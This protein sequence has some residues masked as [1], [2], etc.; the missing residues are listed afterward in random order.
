M[1]SKQS[2]N[3]TA[4][5]VT[6]V[7]GTLV[8][9]GGATALIVNSRNH[10]KAAKAVELPHDLTV[11]G[12]TQNVVNGGGGMRSFREAVDS[13]SLTDAQRQ[14]AYRNMRDVWRQQMDAHVKEF[15]NAKTPDEKYAVLDKH[16]DEM[17]ARMKQWEQDRKEREKEQKADGA[18]GANGGGPNGGR[19]GFAGM[20]EQERKERSES[21]NPDQRAEHMAYFS[22]VQARATERGIPMPGPGGG[23]GPGGGFGRGRR[24]P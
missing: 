12:I 14:Q 4:F 11:E 10:A 8:L 21:A 16:L 18:G 15:M 19:G 20:S 3:S 22:A 5:W 13:E 7:T 24:G 2:H 9:G 23:G 17:Q 6:I 1:L